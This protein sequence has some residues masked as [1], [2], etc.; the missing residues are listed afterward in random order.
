M[1]RGN[2]G[3]SDVRLHRLAPAGIQQQPEPQA[4][5]CERPGQHIARWQLRGVPRIRLG[6]HGQHQRGVLQAACQRPGRASGIAGL[7]R[8]AAVAGLESHQA[9]PAGRQADGAAD[10]GAQVQRPVAGRC[11]SSR[12]GA[13]SARCARQIPGVAR[14]FGVETGQA[15]AEH[16]VV[17][18]GGA[19][20]GDGA[21]LAQPRGRRRLKVKAR[22]GRRRCGAGSG[23]CA[24]HRDVFLQR[25]RHAVQCQRLA[26]PPSGLAGAG[27]GQRGIGIHRAQR[28]Q[29]GLTRAGLGQHGLHDLHR[30][31]LGRPVGGQQRR[32]V[33]AGDHF[34][35]FSAAVNI[36][37]MWP[38]GS[39]L[40]C[41]AATLPSAPIR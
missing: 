39:M 24:R 20:P 21:R 32:G 9:A 40:A 12:T 41:T 18:H 11:R 38:S 8:H 34:F 15:R 27:R 26:G 23:H 30:R 22:L 16:A 2:D 33:Q 36:A 25:H 3:G 5:Q 28:M 7:D 14:R 6:Q 19:G 10:V 31:Q 17:R 29:L 37:P 1:R 4:A 35:S 13:R